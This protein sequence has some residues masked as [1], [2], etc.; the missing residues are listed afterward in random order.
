MIYNVPLTRVLQLQPL[1]PR[2][3]RTMAMHNTYLIHLIR[4]PEEDVELEKSIEEMLYKKV[5]P[6][7]HRV[8]ADHMEE[9]GFR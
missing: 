7:Q 5:T 2:S 9:E 8:R 1:L 6:P 3:I 4:N